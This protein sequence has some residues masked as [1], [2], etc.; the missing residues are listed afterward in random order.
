MKRNGGLKTCV[1][2][3]VAIFTALMLSIGS[4]SASGQPAENDFG[5]FIKYENTFMS[6]SQEG[7]VAD[8]DGNP[9]DVDREYAPRIEA[10]LFFNK[11]LG[12]R[13]R[14][15]SYDTDARSSAGNLFSVDS[16]YWDVELFQNIRVTEKTE[17][18]WSAGIR[19]IDFN[20]SVGGGHGEWRYDS[21]FDSWGVTAALEARRT[22]WYG[23]LYARGRFSIL[24]GDAD[25]LYYYEGSPYNPRKATDNTIYQAELALGYEFNIPLSDRVILKM[26]AGG[27]WQNWSNIGMADSSFGGIGNDDVLEDIGFVGFVLGVGMEF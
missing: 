26:N 25:L 16:S 10:G 6:Y 13:G 15:W 8:A 17:L 19:K 1:F 12:L 5:L 27:E 4:A 9:V 11:G 7:G 2:V 24:A 23:K 18:E 14:Y 21:D 22:I 3:G 20:Q